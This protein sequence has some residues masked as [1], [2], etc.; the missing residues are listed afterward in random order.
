[1]A[2]LA[3]LA[4]LATTAALTLGAAPWEEGNPAFEVCACNSL[5]SRW[6]RI[7]IQERRPVD[8]VGSIKYQFGLHEAQKT[9]GRGCRFDADGFA[10]VVAIFACDDS[11][12]DCGYRG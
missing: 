12:K 3:G 10:D 2:A 8:R 5:A 1:M 7:R 9:A 6:N 4:M 11:G